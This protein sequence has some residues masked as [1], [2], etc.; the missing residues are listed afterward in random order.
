MG[1]PTWFLY[2]HQAHI[3]NK[4][5]HLFGTRWQYKILAVGTGKVLSPKYFQLTLSQGQD[6]AT[7]LRAPGSQNEC[8]LST[9]TTRAWALR[10]A[11]RETQR[12]S[13]CTWLPPSG[14]NNTSGWNKT[15]GRTQSTNTK[16][17]IF[18]KRE[19]SSKGR[20]L[21]R[22]AS[23]LQQTFTE[24]LWRARHWVRISERERQGFH[25]HGV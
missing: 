18:T 1:F 16:L 7:S 3:G 19:I 20:I 2:R 12:K 8:L 25:P 22:V 11:P 10:P 9:W 4:Y 15:R 23:F 24:D 17:G 6:L 14:A 21:A 5:E 13:P